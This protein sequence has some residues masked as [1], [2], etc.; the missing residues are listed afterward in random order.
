MNTRHSLHIH[1]KCPIMNLLDCNWMR[2]RLP[3]LAETLHESGA[4]ASVKCMLLPLAKILSF[5]A[6][7]IPGII[8]ATEPYNFSILFL[9]FFKTAEAKT[10]WFS[11][12]SGDGFKDENFPM[13]ILE[14]GKPTELDF[15]EE[16]T[17]A[18]PDLPGF[19]TATICPRSTPIIWAE[20]C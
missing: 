20:A 14:V 13:P 3:K 4:T 11:A 6:C 10:R 8:T 2:N 16:L 18:T 5:V 19:P 1:K 12:M 15:R 7:L 17:N 9:L